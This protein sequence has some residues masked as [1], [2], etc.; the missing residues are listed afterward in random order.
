[1]TNFESGEN[2]LKDA[3][4]YCEE[5]QHMF[6]KGK[7]NIV[8]RRAQ[9]V[10]ELSLKGILKK[11]GIDYPKIHNVAPLF[12]SLLKEK[13]IEVEKEASDRILFIS[14]LLAKDRA[15]AFYGERIFLKEDAERAQKGA[16]EILEK[17]NEIKNRLDKK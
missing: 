1:M 15:P 17:I 10:V 3:E 13:G 11:M 12:V 5:M 16:I 14:M 7:W 6:E 8:I 9:E 4:S 2:L